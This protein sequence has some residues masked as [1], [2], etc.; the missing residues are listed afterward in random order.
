MKSLARVQMVAMTGAHPVEVDKPMEVAKT[1]LS[2]DDRLKILRDAP[3]DCWIAIVE[4]ES[5]IVASGPEFSDV[6]DEA[7]RLGFSDPL[8]IRTAR[9]WAPTCFMRVPA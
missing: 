6:V 9:V 5:R 7:E 2:S 3:R 1:T 8:M 4:K